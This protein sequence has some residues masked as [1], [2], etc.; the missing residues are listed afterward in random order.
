MAQESDRYHL[1]VFQATAPRF[2]SLTRVRKF[3]N[4]KKKI[5][6]PNPLAQ[7]PEIWHTG[8][9]G[10]TPKGKIWGPLSHFEGVMGTRALALGG[11]AWLS[12]LGHRVATDR[13]AMASL[14]LSVVSCFS[15]DVV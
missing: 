7:K 2:G 8:G 12:F 11:P 13:G 14:S 6:I 4:L 1:P 3:E 10:N 5:S 9:G 15:A